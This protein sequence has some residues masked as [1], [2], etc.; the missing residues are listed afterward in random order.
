MDY[1][2]LATALILIEYFVLTGLVGKAR[3]A[4][5]VQAPAISGDEIFER[6]FRV[7]Q[8]TLEQMVW[9]LPSMWLFA[10]YVHV[11]AAAGLG[12]A[13]F[14]GRILYAR[15]YYA[16]PGKRT[17]GFAIGFLAGLIASVG[18]LIGVVLKLI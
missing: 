11:E 7:Q 12:L 13:F 1:V 10:Y 5:G 3:V 18:A 8:N 6:Y 15:G 4:S 2:A 17:V 16:E 9:F 14:V